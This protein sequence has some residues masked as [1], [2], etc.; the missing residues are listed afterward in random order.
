VRTAR[1]PLHLLFFTKRLLT[2]WLIVDSTNAVLIV[3]P[4]RYR[5]PKFG[6]DSRLLR[7]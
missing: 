1:R 6:M 2:T 3:S 7:M 5:S 4:C